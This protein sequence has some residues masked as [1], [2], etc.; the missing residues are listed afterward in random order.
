M[1]IV[2][3]A[4]LAVHGTFINVAYAAESE[5][6]FDTTDVMS[7]L[8]SSTVDGKKFNVLAYPY[9]ELSDI[10]VINF[11]EFCY[12]YKANMRNNYSLYVYV[13]NPKG[14]NI[15][16][17][18][19][20]NKIQM[21]VAYD[22]NG[23]PC[24][25]HKY[26]LKFCSVS[27]G[28]YK[29]LFYKFRV[30]DVKV[31]GKLF[32]E[33]VN[34]LERRY[35][36]SGI[37]LLTYGQR[38]G[39]EYGVGGTYKFTGYAAG[40][41]PDDKAQSTL[42][43]TVEELETLEL[44]VNHTNF[45]TNVS[46]KGKD[47]YNEVNTVYFSVPERI[48]QTYGNLQKIRAEWWEYKTKMA[49]ITSNKDFY[50]TLLQY[51]GKDVGEYDKNTPVYL[52]SGYEGRASSGLGAPTI[53]NYEWTYNVDLSTKKTALGTVSEMSNCNHISTI[54]PYAFYSPKVD[55]DT[56]F[57]FLYSEPIAG[58]VAAS[59]VA[60]WIYSYSNSLG[61]GF[62]DCNGR[63]LYKDLF[64]NFVDDGRT[65]GYNDKTVDL[66][67]TF[68]L[69]SYNSNHSWWDKLWDYGFSW[70]KTDGDY[71]DV[72]PIYEV[73]ASDLIGDKSTIAANLL[74]NE[75]DVGDLQKYYA[76]ETLKHNRVV[77]FRFANTDYYSAPA[78]RSGY[79]GHIDN[80]D[81]YVAQQT[82]FFDFDIIELTFNRDGVYH[83]IPVVS[84]PIDIINGFTPPATRFEWWK[85][86]IAI[87]LLV[88]LIILL[89]PILP[90]I[91]KGVIWVIS[92]PFKA[93][94][95]IANATRNKHKDD[96]EKPPKEPKEEA[97]YSE[98]EE[99]KNE[100][101]EDG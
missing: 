94:K 89:A 83:V 52:Y 18:A 32:H 3:C 71:K 49:A 16:G 58:E 84:S 27:T 1:M 37:E 38:N 86:I 47:H 100:V 4:A 7:D 46:S 66:S 21:A 53:H 43:C 50:N 61:H 82:V 75:D 51:T 80:T 69:D 56:V 64:E 45:R 20:Q 57:K 59:V 39:T 101:Q 98:K 92:L 99:A 87:L 91:I 31:D 12:S 62:I 88:L 85:I 13:Y 35:D 28:D 55:L 95:G 8:S 73:A 24:K 19:K 40:Y 29:N 15:V 68:S 11:V 42:S 60:E 76:A 81:T 77:L 70:P 9:N 79:S 74:V 97:S 96:G 26:S 34:S 54:M 41:G 14:R 65:M 67:D 23:D 30:V 5:L 44:D 17:D 48:Y 63:Q 33:R 90:Y 36:I 72:S 93:I 78:F 2:L 6:P 22:A 25:Y 10:Q